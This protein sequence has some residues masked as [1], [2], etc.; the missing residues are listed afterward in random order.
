MTQ[1]ISRTKLKTPTIPTIARSRER[2]QWELGFQ[3]GCPLPY[4]PSFLLPLIIH[5]SPVSLPVQ[6]S[7]LLT[8]IPTRVTLFPEDRWSRSYRMK[9]Q[10]G[11]ACVLVAQS[12]S[13]LCDPMDCSLPG[14][15]VPGIL[16]ARTLEWAAIPFSR[17]SSKSRD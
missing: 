10:L 9:W 16:Q 13:T 2:L 11:Q 12:C 4:S 15:S 5:H 6:P 1:V 17:G 14:S 3:A 8:Q 7:T